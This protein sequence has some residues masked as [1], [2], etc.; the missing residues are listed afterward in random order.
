MIAWLGFGERGFI[1]LYQMEMERQDYLKRIQELE[2]K[3]QNLLEE[4]EKLRNDIAYIES[5]ARKELGFVKKNE[6]IF[7]FSKDE[8]MGD[9]DSFK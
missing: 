3:N 6:M 1:H 4:I 8:E 2:G 5:V 9:D 7:R